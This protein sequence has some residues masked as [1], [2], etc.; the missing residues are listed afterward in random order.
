MEMEQGMELVMQEQWEGPYQE[1]PYQEEPCQEGHSAAD[2]SRL[3]A[4]VAFWA[5][6]AG[7]CQ[8][9][10]YPHQICVSH[11]A[12]TSKVTHMATRHVPRQ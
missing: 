6:P 5:A 12:L 9:P 11:A 10:T 8:V 7:R 3:G 1:E 2:C 4:S